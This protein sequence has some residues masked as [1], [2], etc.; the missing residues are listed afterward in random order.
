MNHSI[1]TIQNAIPVGVETDY[2]KKVKERSISFLE[3]SDSI[4]WESLIKD[5][6]FGNIYNK[7]N[8][9]QKKRANTIFSLDGDSKNVSEKE[10][11][12][13][14]HLLD[15]ELKKD[16]GKQAFVFDYKDSFNDNNGLSQANDSEIS[17]IYN[18]LKSRAEDEIQ[19]NKE[20][21][22]IKKQQEIDAKQIKEIRSKLENIKIYKDD[23]TIDDLQLL[24]AID[25]ILTTVDSD[26]A[27]E[28]ILNEIFNN[29]IEYASRLQGLGNGFEFTLND[30]T[31]YRRIPDEKYIRV[32][33]PGMYIKEYDLDYN[34]INY[35]ELKK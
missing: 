24:E 6:T 12:T 3:E 31:S 33:V 26:V 28:E 9:A 10:L 35:K 34:L 4:N 2:V 29:N 18:R 5:T 15:A 30:G 13:F 32:K 16:N 21:E 27:I 1:R 25:I 19:K 22:K 23:G 8:Q 17:V 20:L 7:L 11:R 14:F